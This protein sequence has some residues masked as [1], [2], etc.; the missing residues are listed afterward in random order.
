MGP[1]SRV[2][3]RVVP[4]DADS[5]LLLPGCHVVQIGGAVGKASTA[6]NGGYAA[7]LPA[8]TYAMPMR[9][10]YSYVVEFEREPTLGKMAVG[11]GRIVARETDRE[12]NE[13]PLPIAYDPA[14]IEE[15]VRLAGPIGALD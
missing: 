3:G 6:P 2:D 15:C 10:G 5:Y 14:D 8:L 12:G 7:N 1:I 9:P 4:S 11:R 13:R